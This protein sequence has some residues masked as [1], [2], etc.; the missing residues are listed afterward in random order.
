MGRNGT[1]L[2]LIRMARGL[3]QK[4]LAKKSGVPDSYISLAEQGRLS[5]SEE[6]IRKLEDAL[7]VDFNTVRP[8]FDEFM[9]GI[10][11]E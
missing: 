8:T 10:N 11:Q 1:M 6:H 5:L 3:S 7:G 4:E 9:E 2:K